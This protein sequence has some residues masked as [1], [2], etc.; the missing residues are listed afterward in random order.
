MGG[1]RAL[2]SATLETEN[3]GQQKARW[4]QGDLRRAPRHAGRHG[5]KTA[6]RSG[7][8]TSA[9]SPLRAAAGHD[10]AVTRR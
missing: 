10:D 2:I 3:C 8:P 7:D 9:P 4:R 5:P 6:V 1:S